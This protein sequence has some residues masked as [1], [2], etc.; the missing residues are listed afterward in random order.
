MKKIFS[1]LLA[2]SVAVLSLSAQETEKKQYLPEEGDWSIGFDAKP[3]LNF[4]GNAL[5]GSTDNSLDAFG[6]EPTL[7]DNGPT[8]S[9]MGKYMLTDN[10]AVKANLG[11]LFDNDKEAYY[12]QDDAATILDPL[13]N[14]KVADY[15]STKKS[16]VS[17]MAGVEYRVGKKRIQGVFGGGVLVGVKSNVVKYS[18][19]NKMTAI[20][21]H[22]TTAG[23]FSDVWAGD[24]RTLKQF[25]QTP[26]FY[27]GLVGTAGV[28]FFVAPKVALGAEVS[29]VAAYDVNKQTYTYSEGYNP[30]T[31][32]IERKTDLVS[33]RTGSF[34]LETKNFGGSLYLAFYF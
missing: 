25:S 28:E 11:L 22:P 20:N 6:G 19:G 14:S 26:N 7:T 3:I 21:Q 5:N 33:P 27:A 32:I 24:Y 12:I 1:L 9:I 34:N 30:S 4:V 15:K 16:G 2:A 18:Y 8:V 13:S 17:L 10:F 23:N 31:E 29:V